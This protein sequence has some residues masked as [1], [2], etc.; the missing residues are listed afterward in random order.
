MRAFA[1][2][3]AVVACLWAPSFADAEPPTDTDASSY[4]ALL[5]Y[6]DNARSEPPR[7]L[8]ESESCGVRFLATALL[9]RHD[10]DR[11]RNDFFEQLVID[12]YADRAQN[13]YNIVEPT[14]IARVIDQATIAPEAA[15]DPRVEA[16]IG[17]CNLK[18]KNLWVFTEKAG[19][20][21][22]ARVIR[23]AALNAVL[24][25]TNGDTLAIANA[26]DAHTAGKHEVSRQ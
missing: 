4:A 26:I 22:L 5:P 11:Y 2:R 7:E 20:I 12:D 17:F 25:G 8:A 1:I 16:V 9:Y 6:F 13:N 14:D 21:S 19:R 10:P 24:E 18:E 15:T 23:G 3:A